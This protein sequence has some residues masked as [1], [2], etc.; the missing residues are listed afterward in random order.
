MPSAG[1]LN[2]VM[3]NVAMLN[4][5]APQY[6]SLSSLLSL[7]QYLRIKQGAHRVKH[8]KGAP[9]WYTPALAVNV[10]LGDSGSLGTNALAYLSG[11]SV[12]MRKKFFIAFSTE[13]Q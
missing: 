8:L 5:V 2:V 6:L 4:V 1:M 7:I 11:T 3:L 10:V 12:K 9:L 13:V